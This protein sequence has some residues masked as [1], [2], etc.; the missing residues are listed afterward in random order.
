MG[1]TVASDRRRARRAVTSRPCLLVC[2]A[3][4]VIV[5]SGPAQA[6]ERLAE[7]SDQEMLELG[8]KVIALQVAIR[9][10]TA[11]SAL[12]AVTDLGLDSR[13]YVMVRGWLSIQLEGDLSIASA[14]GDAVPAE[15]Q[16]RIEFLR[17][18]IRAIDLE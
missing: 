13:Y 15:V 7:V 16:A 2:W 6:T 12:A 18:A 10:P 5:V 4:T 14:R 3:L 8:R 17:R 11:R 9:D 1:L